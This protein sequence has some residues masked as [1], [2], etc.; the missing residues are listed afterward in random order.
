[1]TRRHTTTHYPPRRTPTE[2]DI[3][4]RAELLYRK[5]GR[6]PGRDVENWLEAEAWL[7][8]PETPTIH[9]RRHR[10][11]GPPLPDPCAIPSEAHI[12]AG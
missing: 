2:A 7:L 4:R 9:F 12:L 11:P 10:K 5:S 1:M 3:R 6:L 8:N